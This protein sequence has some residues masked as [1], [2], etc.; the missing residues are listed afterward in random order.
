[1]KR[2]PT[3]RSHRRGSLL[4]A[5]LVMI[6]LLAVA[7]L[8]YFDWTFTERVASDAAARQAQARASAES[9]VEFLKVYLSADRATIDQDGGLVD[10]PQR[11]QGVTIEDGGAPELL[12]RFSIVAPRLDYGGFVGA[13]FGLEDESARLNL[14][15]LVVADARDEGVGQDVLMFLPGMTESIADAI[16]DWIDED[17]EPR[18]L[19]AEIDYYSSLTPGYLPQNGPIES[20]EQ[21]LRVRDVTPQLLWGVDQNRNFIAEPEEIEANQFTTLDNTDGSM[22]LGWAAYFTT[23][24]AESNLTDEGLPKINLNADDLETLHGELAE[25]LGEAEANFI[26]AYRQG[27][28]EETDDEDSFDGPGGG[29]D[30]GQDGGQGGAP[31]GGGQPT[32]I[33]DADEIKIDFGAPAS[34][35]IESLLDLVGVRARTV[36]LDGVTETLVESPF[37]DS[38]SD[39]QSYLP[40]LYG[41]CALSDEPSTPGRLNINQAPEAL[42][43]G[44]PGMPPQAVEAILG[45]RNFSSQPQ[46]VERSHPAWILTEGYV[47]LE[48]MR[49]M[50]PYLTAG[51][52]VY[53]AQVV[54]SWGGP[55]PTARLEVVLDTTATPPR[56]VVRRDLTALGA[57][58]SVE[59]LGDVTLAP[60]AAGS[61]I[62]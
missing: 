17:D 49:E 33:K 9:G 22:N 38:A 26:I 45:N 55:G 61:P 13:R 32:D 3:R 53:R 15:R 10:N 16:L 52:D 2:Q 57:G 21:L 12:S 60:P 24:S 56:I 30:G 54:G 1:M 35:S 28:P 8:A 43:Y 27:G 47:T 39:M 42:L 41:Q 46:G 37:T 25:T 14:N 62:P 36:E 19:G 40:L 11:F 50:G 4:L 31:T 18:T 20:L 58:Y 6:A 51:G 23:H 59:Q 5:V 44:V 34:V 48:E 7:N 29:Q